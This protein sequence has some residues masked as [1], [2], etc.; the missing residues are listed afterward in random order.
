MASVSTWLAT[1]W[2]SLLQTVSIITGL[3]VVA[4]Q[5]HDG[6]RDRRLNSQI[7]LYNI[8]REL[9]SQGFSHPQLFDILVD[10]AKVDPVLERRY[11]QLWLNQLSLLHSFK[12]QGVMQKEVAE[13]FDADLHD[14]MGMSNMQRHW[15]HYAKYY[16]AS[17]QASVNQLL[18][19]AGQEPRRSGIKHLFRY[20]FKRRTR[21]PQ[22]ALTGRSG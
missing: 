17:F 3:V 10:K 11:L 16:P 19:K 2:F 5:Q 18:H 8:N 12:I 20:F 6:N 14:I 21:H 9:I 4:K 15:D 13:S 22:K 7:Q 1:N